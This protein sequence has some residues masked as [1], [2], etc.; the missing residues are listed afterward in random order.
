MEKI[1]NYFNK[2]NV[3]LILFQ[4]INKKETKHLF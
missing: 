1:Q 3:N 4:Q 2:K